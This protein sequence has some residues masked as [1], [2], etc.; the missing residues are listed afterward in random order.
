MPWDRFED[1]AAILRVVEKRAA[2]ARGA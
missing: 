2:L 1:E